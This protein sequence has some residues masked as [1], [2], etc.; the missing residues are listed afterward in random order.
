MSF[1]FLI[2]PYT[3]CILL[4]LRVIIHFYDND[5]L[6]YMNRY[7]NSLAFT[8]NVIVRGVSWAG[9]SLSAGMPFRISHGLDER[10]FLYHI[11]SCSSG[12]DAFSIRCRKEC[13]QHR[14]DQF[15]KS[16]GG[17]S[18]AP[19][20]I[21]R[22]KKIP[23]RADVAG[24]ALS[25]VANVAVDLFAPEYALLYKGLVAAAEVSKYGAATFMVRKDIGSII[26]T[27]TKIL[28]DESA[29]IAGV[30]MEDMTFGLYYLLA[31]TRGEWG[32]SQSAIEQEHRHCTNISDAELARIQW[33][34]NLA[35]WAYEEDI[36][37]LQ[38][39]VHHQGFEIIVCTPGNA[40]S[41]PAFH[42]LAHQQNKLIVI[43]VRGTKDFKDI[44]SDLDCKPTPFTMPG[45]ATAS[46]E[47]YSH[48]GMNEAA[49][50]LISETIEILRL[51]VK[52]GFTPV[53]TGHSLGG[54]VATLAVAKLAPEFSK[55]GLKCYGY[56]N[57][58]VMS[59]ELATSAR[60]HTVSVCHEHDVIPRLSSGNV[61]R[62]LMSLV[63]FRENFKGKEVALSKGLARGFLAKSFGASGIAV[64][65]GGER[66]VVGSAFADMKVSIATICGSLPELKIPGR[67]I[68]VYKVEG[69][70][71]IKE[72]PDFNFAPL[73]R[74]EPFLDMVNC[75]SNKPYKEAL[76][77]ARVAAALGTNLV[78]VP[79]T[80]FDASVTEC[81]VCARDFCWA[82][83]FSSP[84]HRDLIGRIPCALCGMACCP[85]CTEHTKALPNLGMPMPQRVCNECYFLPPQDAKYSNMPPK[86]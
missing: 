48:E 29:N 78:R 59:S 76:E 3:T 9:L 43:T 35:T 44:L 24:K 22:D 10:L 6:R 85:Q 61:S 63:S 86:W 72:A 12:G 84:T 80:G 38:R 57:P 55:V 64:D 46:S 31:K 60:A 71:R 13:W 36:V 15:L 81:K 41:R 49:D 8:T 68:H 79:W 53:F 47:H 66:E 23:T 30:T 45:E 11:L 70:Y 77:S 21:C 37:A 83:T 50:W 18:I 52:S 25:S 27:M 67:I 16:R 82:E 51:F 34:H 56:G 75:H 54:G 39:L 2:A 33:M 65:T 73:N 74:I 4:L 28:E 58:P 17:V 26:S 1:I 40:K 5:I 20:Q 19:L 7:I 69:V 42:V 32:E 62:L 14:A